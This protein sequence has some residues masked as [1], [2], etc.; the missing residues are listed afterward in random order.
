M[1]MPPPTEPGIEADRARPDA[2]ADP[3]AA[4]GFILSQDIANMTEVQAGMK[5]RGFA[6][7][8]TNPVQESTVH[9]LHRVIREYVYGE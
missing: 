3:V 8:R 7:A 1:S 4:F 5:S 6:G 2:L 9:N